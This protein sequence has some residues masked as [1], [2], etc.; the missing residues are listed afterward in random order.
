LASI[1]TLES[2]R[3]NLE[4]ELEKIKRTAEGLSQSQSPSA[5]SSSSVERIK[6][7]YNNVLQILVTIF[8]VKC[9]H[10]FTLYVL[11]TLDQILESQRGTEGHEGGTY[12][13]GERLPPYAK[14]IKAVR[15]NSKRIN[16]TERKQ[17]NI[18]S[19]S[20]RLPCI[21]QLHLSV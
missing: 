4:S 8:H 2:E 19:A 1:G 18:S 5:G 9:S 16:Q 17:G 13:K 21:F 15:C 12:E 10:V 20:F 3:Q 14:R 11:W 7:R 6:E